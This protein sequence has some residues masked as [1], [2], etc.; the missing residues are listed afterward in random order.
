MRVG[1]NL[2]FYTKPRLLN[3]KKSSQKTT[4]TFTAK[5]YELPAINV[6]SAYDAMVL[7]NFLSLG[8][9]L[10]SSDDDVCPEN[11]QIRQTNLSFLEKLKS[12]EDKKIFIEHYKDVTGFPNLKLVSEKIEKEFILGI[13][14]SLFDLETNCI[15]AG[16]DGTCSVGK[17]RAFPGSDLDKA[18]VVLE[19][20]GN[21]NRDLEVIEKFKA[22]LWN[23]I[24]Q[25]L[26]SFNHD[27]SFPNI[28]TTL[29]IK[30]KLNKIESK[31]KNINIDKN[32][33]NKLLEEEYVNL[34]K[35]AEY[36]I[37]ISKN[38]D[39]E[40][41]DPEIEITKEDLKNFGYFIESLRDGKYLIKTD[42]FEYLKK[43]LEKSDFYNFSNLAQMKAMNKAVNEG[44]ENKTK[45]LLRENFEKTFN[46]WDLDKQLDFIKTLIKYSCEDNDS[47]NEFFRND[48][49]VKDAYK[50]LL[51]I[52]TQGDR[53]IYN[54]IEFEN[55]SNGIRLKYA[56][57]RTVDVYAG[58]SENVLWIDS[59]DAL[60]IRQVLRVINKLK[61]NP[62]FSKIDR[63]QCE[64]PQGT[65]K[66]FY[67]TKYF[68][69][70]YKQ[71]FERIL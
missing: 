30:D 9:Y 43:D 15:L 21:L 56:E 6:K 13:K 69:A 47:F 64:K 41:N 20:S 71:I 10:D 51:N 68:S 70:K 58:F 59:S 33:L 66:G 65:L 23:N 53:S 62:I 48:R 4:F 3:F 50:P 7:Y 42:Q 19:S 12:Q 34:E 8:N 44:R 29:Q 46:S 26:L 2:A 35:A 14:K 18:F 36:N 49:N 40:V 11:K 38:F 24:D 1:T 16:Y 63:I 25:R 67:A 54:R 31:I 32:Y 27:I 55:I 28:F 39:I 60:A 61:Q 22:N 5:P 37:L 17:K 57:D 45:I 52:L